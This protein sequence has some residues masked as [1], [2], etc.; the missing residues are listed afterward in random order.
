MAV[1][2]VF[3]WSHAAC[4][5]NRCEMIF[6]PEVSGGR[7]GARR[8][9]PSVETSRSELT[10]GVEANERRKGGILVH[11]RRGAK[12]I[13][14]WV[15]WPLSREKPERCEEQIQLETGY[16]QVITEVLRKIR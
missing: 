10:G 12:R 4:W 5:K 8:I 6:Q 16:C 7:K 9:F 14:Y 15:V 3:V 2:P 13:C 1:N 11:L